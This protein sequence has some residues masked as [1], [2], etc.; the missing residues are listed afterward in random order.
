MYNRIVVPLDGSERAEAAIPH[1][2]ALARGLVAPLHLIRVVDFDAMR[3]R[4]PPDDPE[5]L[6]REAAA[7]EAMAAEYLAL[8][9]RSLAAAVAGVSVE[10]GR[11]VP[12]LQLRERTRAGDLLV[13]V[14]GGSARPGRIAA[15]A[16]TW[17]DT[18][19]LLARDTPHQPPHVP[20]S[21]AG[22]GPAGTM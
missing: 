17:A 4:V 10:V 21:T 20:G 9:A 14:A 18:P 22:H 3:G 2:V 15:A 12:A 11:G 16:L 13:L 6:E 1:A 5:G 7:E 19:V 8:V